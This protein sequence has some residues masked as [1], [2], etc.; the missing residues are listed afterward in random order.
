ML[1][2]KGNMAIFM[3]KVPAANDRFSQGL[4]PVDLKTHAEARGLEE[5]WS[6]KTSSRDRRRLQN[7]LNQRAYR[8]PPSAFGNIVT[9]SIA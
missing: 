5:D 4:I 1:L 6:G 7:R 8:K 2:S 9:K 3:F